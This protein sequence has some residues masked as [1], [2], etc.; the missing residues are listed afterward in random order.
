MKTTFSARFKA[1]FTVLLLTFMS[2]SAPLSTVYA[3]PAGNNGTLKVHEIGTPTGTENNDPKVC[4]FNFEGFGFDPTQ[5]GYIMIDTQGGSSPVGQ[6]AGPFSFGPTDGA[7]YA[8]SQDF[9]TPTGTT[10]VDGTYKATLYGKDTGGQIDLQDD[11]AKSKVFKVDCSGRTQT[12]TPS[13]VSFNDEC[14]TANDT[15]TIATTSG[16]GFKLGGN[17]LAAGV[18]PGTGTIT[19]DAFAEAGYSLLGATTWQHTFSDAVCPPT[20]VGATAPTMIDLTCDEAGS[21]TIPEKT[22]VIY[23]VDGDTST[24]GKYTVN[25]S[26][27]IIV[28]VEAAPGYVIDGQ[29]EWTFNFTS[30]ENCDEGEDVCPNINETQSQVPDG[31][32]V[33]ILGNCVTPGRGGDDT[34]TTPPTTPTIEILT[35]AA[36][37]PT[38]S[39]TPQTKSEQLTNTGMPVLL[40]SII[41]L[42]IIGLAASVELISRR[43]KHLHNLNS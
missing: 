7:G 17:T 29:T 40:N 20:K 25:T 16:V 22:G 41:A 42:T 23:K 8:I 34:P 26:K 39:S 6:D 5:S 35:V 18:Y 27:T 24:A 3:A 14:G 32:L 4:A 37:T 36:T 33:D 11:K 13:A 28:T 21:Y 9:N 19:I 12:V 30:P 2:A 38:V 31:M 1:A 10:I 15:Y 43:Q